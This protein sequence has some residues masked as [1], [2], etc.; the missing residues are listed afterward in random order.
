MATFETKGIALF[1]Q[2]TP[3]I[4]AASAFDEMLQTSR[5]L[6]Q[7]LD[8]QLVDE[9]MQPLSVTR[10]SAIRGQLSRFSN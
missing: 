1:M 4:D 2:V 7:R 8:A 10:I 9:K 3:G 6:S 5:Q